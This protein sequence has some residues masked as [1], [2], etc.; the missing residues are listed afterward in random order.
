MKIK[1]YELVQTCSAC[2][3][4]YDVFKDGKIVGYLRL[5]HG[6]FRADVPDCG[7]KTVYTSNTKG[8]GCFEPEEKELELNNAIEAIDFHCGPNGSIECKNQVF[9]TKC[10]LSYATVYLNLYKESL[11][12]LDDRFSS[13]KKTTEEIL[14]ELQKQKELLKNYEK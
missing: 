8:D 9:E 10:Y 12:K 1:D 14:K 7:G 4:Q 6:S 2:P 5:R 13:A 11:D 3:E